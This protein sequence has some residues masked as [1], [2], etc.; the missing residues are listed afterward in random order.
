MCIIY[1]NREQPIT[2]Q[3][4]IDK[5]SHHQNPCG[6]SKFKIS[7]CRSNIY[8]RTDLKDIRSRFDQVRPVVSHL[9]FCLP[10]IPPTPNNI[11]E[12][13]KCPQIQFYKEALFV[14]Y[15][16]NENISLISDPIPIKYLSEGTKILRSIIAPIIKEYD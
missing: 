9:E 2:S 3:G 16:N 1:I 6:K 12:G 11:G 13:L 15:N 4:T 7:P 8:H 5:L 14:Q 10:E